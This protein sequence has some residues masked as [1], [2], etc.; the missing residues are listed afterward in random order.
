MGMYDTVRVRYLMPEPAFQDRDFQTKD[1]GCWLDSYE[2]SATGYL[3]RTDNAGGEAVY[4]IDTSD[5][6]APFDLTFDTNNGVMEM[7]DYEVRNDPG[8]GLVIF[9][10]RFQDG[11]CVGIQRRRDA[12]E[13]Y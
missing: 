6:D 3:I 8:S 2:I 10:A 11:K 1:L 4:A 5:T 9:Q 13:Q 7:V 12:G